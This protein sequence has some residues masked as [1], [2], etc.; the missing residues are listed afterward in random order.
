[1]DLGPQRTVAGEFQIM[2]AIVYALLYIGR[3]GCDLQLK[4]TV[5]NAPFGGYVALVGQHT[6]CIIEAILGL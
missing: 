2:H 4:P 5:G 1:M 6:V 3:H